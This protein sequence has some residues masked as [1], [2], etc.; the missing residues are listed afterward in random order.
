MKGFRLLFTC[1]FVLV[2]TCD[3][4]MNADV[5]ATKVCSLTCDYSLNP[6]GIDNT[7]PL[8][9]WQ[10]QSG[11]R[12]IKQ[13]AYRILVASAPQL[14]DAGKGD[15]W[16]SKKIYS[17][18][19]QNIH[20]K[21]AH[22]KSGKYYY[23]KVMVWTEDEKPLAWSDDAYWSMGLLSRK[24]WQ[25]SW[26]SNR[27]DAVDT[28]RKWF[29][30][31]TEKGT[32]VA[33]DTAAIYMRKGVNLQKQVK[34]A[35]AF[36]SGLGY[37][38]LYINGK[39]Q[40]NHVMDPV[41]TDYQ[42]RVSYVTYDVTRALQQGVNVLGVILG[43]GF[44]NSPTE[45]L[46][47]TEK[48]HWKTAPKVLLNLLIE[49]VDGDKLVVVTDS[50]WKWNT[51]EIVYNSIRS[52]ETIDH[53]KRQKDWNIRTF[54]DVTWK[55]SVI[56]PAPLGELH[57]QIVPPMRINESVR[58]KAINEPKKDIY[59]VDFGKNFTGWI[60]LR[61][62]GKPG[63][64]I[65]CWYNEALN[66]DGTLNKK[67]SSGHTGG[68]FQKEEFILGSDGEEYFEPRFTYHGFRYVQLEGL[69]QVPAIDEIYAKS[70]HTSLDTTGYFACSDELV[71][72]LQQA[73][74]RTLLNSI[75]G[76]PAEEPT[77][78]KMGWTQDAGVT[79]DSYLYNFNSVNAYRK[80]LQDFIDAQEPNGHIPCIVPT[81]GWAFVDSV[82]GRVHTDDP[83]WGGTIFIIAEK[84]FQYTGDAGVIQYAFDAMK[85]YVDY[86]ATTAKNDLI[87]WSLG[88]WL[89]GDRRPPVEQVSTAAYYWMNERLAAFAKILNKNSIADEY[90]KNA[91]RI[92]DAYNAAFLDTASG[93]YKEGSQ[94]AQAL[95]LYLGMVPQ[96]MI[97]QVENRLIEAIEMNDNHVNVGFVGV[98]PFLNY[99]SENGF[100]EKCYEVFKQKESPGW[101]HMVANGQSTLG[102]NLNSKGYGTGHHPF[103]AHIGYWLYKYL[104]GIQAD[105]EYPGFQKFVIAPQFMT[106]LNWVSTETHSLYGKIVSSWKR[107][108][109]KIN[110]TVSIPGNT[111]AKLILPFSEKDR[112]TMN[113]HDFNDI[114]AIKCVEKKKEQVIYELGS[115]DYELMIHQ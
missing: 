47:Q 31:W 105:T 20:Y 22:L 17:G 66:E 53:R 52:G 89:G 30:K 75:H 25:G 61:V 33:S 28:T 79:M 42:K 56:V 12:N 41:F 114:S 102:E 112:I 76:M 37:Y 109:E 46:F 106:D 5:T 94:T 90:S 39:K 3:Y 59:V 68:R 44:Y 93:W 4:A 83:W 32:Y 13:T 108:G 65:E 18:Q 62:K 104:G 110:V 88:D 43:N 14:L 16:D 19:S 6:L 95:P 36:I 49:Y 72:Q 84:L 101:L 11:Q 74:Q 34:Q 48:A 8:L 113:G 26:I 40:G 45:D 107:E 77:R 98:V 86:V 55:N 50:S 96:S 60:A 78:E 57:S 103:G 100:M 73:V 111:F 38:E 92:K 10:L 63:Q 29:R 54:D 2:S 64:K 9:G 97:P 69:T 71:N 70:V 87:Y 1:I 82:G 51:G 15:V 23:W 67:Y 91:N 7:M 24:D 80:C 27:F 81:N 35:T 115:G 85:A 58:P 99:L 21:G